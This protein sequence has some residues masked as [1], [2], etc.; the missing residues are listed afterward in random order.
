MQK[1]RD[2]FNPSAKIFVDIYQQDDPA[3]KTQYI[4]FDK[5]INQSIF[6]DKHWTQSQKL[7]KGK[8]VIVIGHNQTGRDSVLIKLGIS[9][10]KN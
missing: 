10:D 4:I 6:C 7:S 5:K 1:L 8:Y 2:N 9:G 3:F